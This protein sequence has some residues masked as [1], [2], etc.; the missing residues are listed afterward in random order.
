M[1]ATRSGTLGKLPRPDRLVSNDLKNLDEVPAG[2]QKLA[3]PGDSAE[4]LQPLLSFAPI[5]VG[6]SEK[7]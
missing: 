1:A 6:L 5:M 7:R 3:F 2:L 4:S